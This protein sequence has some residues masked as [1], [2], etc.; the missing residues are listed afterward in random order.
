[1]IG[2]VL[3][4]WCPFCNWFLDDPGPTI[5]TYPGALV[6]ILTA[7]VLYR[8]YLAKIDR[9]LQAHLDQHV[10]EMVAATQ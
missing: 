3:R 2:Y 5:E 4:R 9:V 1:M 8:M 7:D 6:P 10:E